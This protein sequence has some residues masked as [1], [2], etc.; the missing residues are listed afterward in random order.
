MSRFGE[1]VKRLRR[2]SRDLRL[3]LDSRAVSRQ[4]ALDA[5]AQVRTNRRRDGIS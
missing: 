2:D 5:I 1:Y 4:A 3:I